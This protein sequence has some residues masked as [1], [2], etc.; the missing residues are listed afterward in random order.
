VRQRA[1]LSAAKILWGRELPTP[2][3]ETLSPWYAVHTRFQHERVIAQHLMNKGIET[4]LPLY[5]AVHRWKDRN[6][7]ISAPLFPCY[8]FLRSSREHKLDIVSIPGVVSLIGSPSG[9]SEIPATEIETV[10]RAVESSSP[11]RPHPFLVSGDRV[12]IK[13]G[14]LEGTEG[15][16]IRSK[17]LFRLIISVEML[18][19]SAAVE[20][21]I[22][23]VERVSNRLI[24]A[25]PWQPAALPRSAA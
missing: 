21:D 10:R 16:L 23:A 24:S 18:G 1:K 2:S 3:A 13:F 17:N 15:I 12:R 8:V 22:T 11:I 7:E 6:K 4:F 14:A 9:P 19:R 5:S 20:I 25:R